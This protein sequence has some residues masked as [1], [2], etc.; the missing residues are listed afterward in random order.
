MKN[1]KTLTETYPLL[2]QHE[3]NSLMPF[4]MFGFECDIGWY[5]IIENACWLMYSKYHQAEQDL[6]YVNDLLNNIERSLQDRLPYSPELTIEKLTETLT[7]RKEKAQKSVEEAKESMP[8]V[9]QIKEKFGTLR[10]YIDYGGPEA[11]AIVNFAEAMSA[12][13]CEVCGNLGQPFRIGWHRTLCR[14]HADLN[15]G[16]ENVDNYLKYKDELENSY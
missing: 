6:K 11:Q 7:E 4:P 1:Y 8:R 10:F 13:T 9:A 14:E 12:T 5:N 3:E 2:F 16:K 15:Y